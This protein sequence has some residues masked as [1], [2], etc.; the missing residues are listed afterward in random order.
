MS[1]ACFAAGTCERIEAAIASPDT[2][3]TDR[4]DGHIEPQGGRI[5]PGS[6]TTAVS[7]LPQGTHSARIATAGS[8]PAAR[9]A[10]PRHAAIPT[11]A[12]S[13][14]APTNVSGSWTV[15]PKSKL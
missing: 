13:I 15:T 7:G 12:S 6:I 9:D 4:V 3:P 8:T 2:H 10:G 11:T 14:V 5:T 1:T